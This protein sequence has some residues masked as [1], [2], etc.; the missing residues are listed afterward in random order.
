MAQD[1]GSCCKNSNT[2]KA[3]LA[4]GKKAPR[5]LS[6]T[7]LPTAP[8]VPAAPA[9]SG[10]RVGSQLRPGTGAVE[11]TLFLVGRTHFPAQSLP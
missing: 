1:L 8:T 4:S 2:R 6:G 5:V 7:P 10:W 11:Q 3:S 9:G